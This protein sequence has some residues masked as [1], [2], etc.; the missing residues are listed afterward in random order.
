MKNLFV[1]YFTF[2]IFIIKG[3]LPARENAIQYSV[4]ITEMIFLN[5]SGAQ[6]LIPMYP[7]GQVRQPYSYSIPSPRLFKNSSTG[8]KTTFGHVG[9]CGIYT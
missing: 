2:D 8:A 5:L 6:E 7:G 4:S 9:H 3:I 1:R